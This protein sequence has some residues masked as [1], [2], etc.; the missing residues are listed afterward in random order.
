M[1]TASASDRTDEPTDCLDAASHL[2]SLQ[3]QSVRLFF[4]AV[5]FLEPS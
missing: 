2:H 5:C 3:L 4:I 1:L